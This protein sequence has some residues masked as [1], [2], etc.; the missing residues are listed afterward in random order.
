MLNLMPN[1]NPH[2]AYKQA[3]VDTATPEKLLIMLFNGGIKFL[4][5]GEQALEQRD[6]TIANLSLIKVQD[7]L[8]ELIDTLD[9]ERGGEISQNLYNLYVFYRNEVIN[10]NINKDFARLK[11]VLDFFTVFRDTWIQAA[12]LIRLGAR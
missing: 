9:M 6:Y 2:A 10:A 5:Q 12:Q 1:G 11:P 8:T 4:H 3:S 7:I